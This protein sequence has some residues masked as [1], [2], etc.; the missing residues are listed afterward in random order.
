MIKMTQTLL[1][2]PPATGA[3]KIA[4]PRINLLAWTA[5]ILITD[6]FNRITAF[7]KQGIMMMGST[8]YVPNATSVV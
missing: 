1:V 6:I 7:V 4:Q 3:A 2:A 8:V 5:M